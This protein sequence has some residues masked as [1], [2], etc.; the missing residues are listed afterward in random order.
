MAAEHRR[1]SGSFAR[2]AD[3]DGQDLTPARRIGFELGELIQLALVQ[4]CDLEN[5]AIITDISHPDL[6]P[7]LVGGE[8]NRRNKSQITNPKTQTNP[9]IQ[10]PNDKLRTGRFGI[11]RLVLEICL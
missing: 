9:K 8:E 3:E 6:N 1:T 4:S 11:C 7:I 10:I 2:L 5:H